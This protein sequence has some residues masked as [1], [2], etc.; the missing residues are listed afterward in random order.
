MKLVRLIEI[1]LK[2]TYSEVLMSCGLDDHDSIT[3][4]A[5]IF[6]HHHFVQTGSGVQPASYPVG[7]RGPFTWDKVAVV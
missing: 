6:S 5:G 2:E 7:I 3:G 4:R 1:C